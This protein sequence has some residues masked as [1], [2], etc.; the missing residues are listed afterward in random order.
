MSKLYISDKNAFKNFFLISFIS[1]IL[2]ILSVIFIGI[3]LYSLFE[4]NTE[5]PL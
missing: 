2:E 1:D 5:A 4:I 3:A